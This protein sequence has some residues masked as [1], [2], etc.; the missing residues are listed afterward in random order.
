[1]AHPASNRVT[2]QPSDWLRV[3]ACPACDT[4]PTHEGARLTRRDYLFSGKAIAV[5]QDLRL[6]TCECGLVYKTLMAA[7]RL[8]ERLTREANADL[9]TSSYDFVPET[10]LLRQHAAAGYSVLDIG[11]AGGGFLNAVA[12]DA[13]R[14]SAL[15]IVRFDRLEL[16]ADGEFIT[17]FLDDP[18]LVWGGEPY[19][20]VS[21]FDV[22]E[23][24][25]DP[26]V[27][28]ANLRKLVAP[29]GIVVLETGDCGAIDRV[30]RWYYTSLLEHHI[31]W[32]VRSLEAVAGKFGFTVLS[33]KRKRH[34]TAPGRTTLAQKIKRAAYAAAPSLY[35]WVQG[36]A[37]FDG[38][39]PQVP[40]QRDH[41]QVILRQADGETAR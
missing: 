8:M 2:T 41:M 9:W 3:A 18:N 20:V 36:I 37:G 11:A 10:A 15:D 40:G 19:D 29:D 33:A 30:D 12:G 25:Y 26:N 23:H 21:C 7:P 39:V 1:M 6:V 38:A 35:H 4:A 22:F 13:G 17:A 14:R 34:K 31:F 28:M 24:F 5:P 16:S 32:D 27:A